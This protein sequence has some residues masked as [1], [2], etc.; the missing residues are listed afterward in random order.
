MPA[1]VINYDLKKEHVAVAEVAS[2]GCDDRT[3][4]VD[5]AFVSFGIDS[6][7]NVVVLVSVRRM[8]LCFAEMVVNFKAVDAIFGG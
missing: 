5:G 4:L 6:G 1:V 3:P 8:R 7:V 2:D